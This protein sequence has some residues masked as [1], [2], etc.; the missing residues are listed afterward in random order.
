[1]KIIIIIIKKK[2]KKKGTACFQRTEGP[3]ATYKQ[4]IPLLNMINISKN[5]SLVKPDLMDQ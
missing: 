3:L 5:T 1:M 2:K 4:C